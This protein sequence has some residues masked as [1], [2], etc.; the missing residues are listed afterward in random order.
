MCSSDLGGLRHGGTVVASGRCVKDSSR[1]SSLPARVLPHKRQ[2]DWG[3][4]VVPIDSADDPRLADYRNI[5][6]PDLVAA[7]GIFIAEGRLV[8]RRLLESSRMP[9]RSVMV[10]AAA[11]ESMRDVLDD[12][13]GVPV[14]LV[15]QAVMNSISGFNMHRGCLAVVSAR[16][17]DLEHA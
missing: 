14:Y 6:D 12:R 5:P 15:P 9:T 13:N 10:T 4:P 16:L 1:H 8:V 3:V 11:L 7:G 17:D 2:L